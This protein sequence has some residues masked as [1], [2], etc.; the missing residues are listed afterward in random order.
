MAVAREVVSAGT[1]TEPLTISLLV[2]D[3]QAASEAIQFMREHAP[4]YGIDPGRVG[5]VG[6]SA[7]AI[8]ANQESYL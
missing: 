4:K 1:A 8:T 7:G 6:G 5:L 3:S 2:D